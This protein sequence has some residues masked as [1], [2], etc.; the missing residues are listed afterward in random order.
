MYGWDLKRKLV[1]RGANL[2]T[3]IIL[4]PGVS[5]VTGSFRCAPSLWGFDCLAQAEAHG[6]L[7][8]LPD[9]D[10]AQADRTDPIPGIRLSNGDHRPSPS[11][12]LHRRR[13]RDHVRRPPVWRKQDGRGRDRCVR[14]RVVDLVQVGLSAVVRVYCRCN[15]QEHVCADFSQRCRLPYIECSYKKSE[16]SRLRSRSSSRIPYPDQLACSL[17]SSSPGALNEVQHGRRRR[18]GSTVQACPT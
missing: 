15:E 3:A 13:G 12:G 11:H 10:P 2:L 9:P 8:T 7:Q 14:E 18:A 5:D 4:A 17:P 16:P 1:S 6:Q